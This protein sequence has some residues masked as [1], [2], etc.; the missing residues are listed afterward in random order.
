MSVLKRRWPRAVF[1]DSKGTL[2][3][4]PESWRAA[5]RDIVSKYQAPIDADRFLEEWLRLFESYHRRAASFRYTPVAELMQEALVTAFKLHGI[6]GVPEDVDLVLSRQQ[7]V[8]LYPETEAAL[9]E[10]Q[11]LGVKILI[12]SDVETKYLDMYVGKFRDFKPDFVGTTEQAGFH[13]PNPLTYDWVL[14]QVGLQPRDVIYCA[15][16]TFDCQGAMAFGLVTA[17]LRRPQGFMSNV[18]FM[19]G[20]LAADYEIEDL[21]DLTRIL[22]ANL[23]A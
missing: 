3:D 5:A 1:Y 19:A 13:K 7:Q 14:R 11:R 4:W 2:F 22:E 6:P 15:G 23:K 8:R 10:Q 20:D 17:W 12:Y 9:R 18:P 21:N 16:P